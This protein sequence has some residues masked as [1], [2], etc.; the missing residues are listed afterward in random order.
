MRRILLG[1]TLGVLAENKALRA[2]IGIFL[3]VGGAIV[4]REIMPYHDKTTSYLHYWAMWQIGATFF[5]GMIITA[6]PFSYEEFLLGSLLT[7]SNLSTPALALLM[8]W[9]GYKQRA[10]ERVQVAPSKVLTS[11]ADAEPESDA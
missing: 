4:Q 9:G 11:T 2:A 8:H 6:R 5:C 3:A 7:I 1:V 10:L